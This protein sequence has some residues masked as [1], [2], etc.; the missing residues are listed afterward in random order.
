VAC[1]CA[2]GQ[3]LE[4]LDDQL[5]CGDSLLDFKWKKEFP[6]IF[7]DGGF[8]VVVGNPPYVRQEYLKQHKE[9]LKDNYDVFNSN[10]DLYAY[11]LELGVS[12]K[13]EFGYFG[14]IVTNKW[15]RA[16]YGENL[17]KYLVENGLFSITDFGDLDVFPGVAAYP[18]IVCCSGDK[19]MKKYFVQRYLALNLQTCQKRLKRMGHLLVQKI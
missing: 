5:K 10:N 8:D 16:E 13:K 3:K 7:K 1:E 11:F 4:E 17:R 18:V 19:N 6:T 2:K 14:M 15:M 12:I 9:N